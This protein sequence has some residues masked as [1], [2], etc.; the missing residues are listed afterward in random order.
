MNALTGQGSGPFRRRPPLSPA[1]LIPE[2]QRLTRTGRLREGGVMAERFESGGVR[3][4]R[5]AVVLYGGV[6]SPFTCTA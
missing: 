5:L 6:C 4:V 3:E 1:S 2:T